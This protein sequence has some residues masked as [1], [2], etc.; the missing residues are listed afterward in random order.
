LTRRVG[1]LLREFLREKGW[2]GS[3]PYEGLFR[4]WPQIAGGALAGHARLADVRGGLLIVEVDHPGW[5]QMVQLRQ[6]TL[7]EAA[8]RT[9]PGLRIDGIRIRLVSRIPDDR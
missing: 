7:L 3:N 1:D 9:V 4:G 8:R 2:L 5:V 6:R